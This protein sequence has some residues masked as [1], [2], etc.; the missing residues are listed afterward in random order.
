MYRIKKNAHGYYIDHE[1]LGA[2]FLPEEMLDFIVMYLIKEPG[3]E[4]GLE[5]FV[6]NYNAT[7]PEGREIK[8]D[9]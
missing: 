5:T 3:T 4:A 2:I 7:I 6:N 1:L 9:E 8:K